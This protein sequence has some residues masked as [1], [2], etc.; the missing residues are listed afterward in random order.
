MTEFKESTNTTSA[1]TAPG[2]AHPVEFATS[3]DRLIFKDNDVNGLTNKSLIVPTASTAVNIHDN[4]SYNPIGSITNP[5]GTSTIGLY[6][7]TTATIT[8][9]TDYTIV[10]CPVLV[11]V[12]L[13]TVSDITIKDPAGNTVS[14]AETSIKSRYIPVGFKLRVTHTG[15]PTTTVFGV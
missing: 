13:G 12:T 10:G 9:A 1:G 6:G 5:I 11:T 2:S 15:A 8:T 7:G 14:S 4:L 3:V